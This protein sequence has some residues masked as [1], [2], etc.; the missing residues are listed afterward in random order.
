MALFKK[1]EKKQSKLRLAIFGPSGSGKTYSALAIASGLGRSIAV[2]DT[3]H[4]SAAK[5]AN[6][7]DFDIADLEDKS[8]ESYIKTI[9]QAMYQFDVLIIDSLSHA[10]KWAISEAERI[11]ATSFRNNTWAG[12]SKVTPQHDA[13]VDAILSYTGHIICTMR[14]KTDWSI[15]TESGKSKPVRVGLAPNQGKDIEYEFD[16]LIELTVEHY[17]KFIKDRTGKFQDKVIQKPGVDLGKELKEWLNEGKPAVASK[18]KSTN[19]EFDL[20]AKKINNASSV[21]EIKNE[22]GPEIRK[23]FTDNDLNQLMV[24]GSDKIKELENEQ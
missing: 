7:F 13:L 12:W 14:S 15:D 23:K 9:K 18:A 20:Y 4:G 5:Y 24:I 2:I 16:E 21:D 19:P 6:V 3:E 17:G 1:A 11:G 8:I 10:W 22:I